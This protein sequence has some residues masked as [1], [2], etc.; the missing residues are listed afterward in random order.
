MK[1][2]GKTMPRNQREYL[3]R[4]ADQ[5]NNDL[6]RSLEKLMQLSETYKAEHP[7]YEKYVLLIA[8]QVT[9]AQDDL[10][11]FRAKFM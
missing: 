8:A 9:M 4:F 2:T 10:K 5:A 1:G 11:T 3:L 7:D 6:D